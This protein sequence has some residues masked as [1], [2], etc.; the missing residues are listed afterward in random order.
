MKVLGLLLVTFGLLG[1][2]K[3]EPAPAPAPMWFLESY[4]ADKGFT[5]SKDMLVDYVVTCE[6]FRPNTV[7][8]YSDPSTGSVAAHGDCTALLPVVGSLEGLSGPVTIRDN[9]LLLRANGGEYAF[10]IV[11][12]RGIGAE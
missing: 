6:S 4:D 8:F 2:Q 9:H 7:T 12:V 1:C 3:A 11:A 10:K 5:F